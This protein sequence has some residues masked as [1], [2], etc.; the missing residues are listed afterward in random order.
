M[1]FDPVAALQVL[2]R[3]QVRFVLIGR[4]AGRLWGSATMTLE[5]LAAVRDER[6]RPESVD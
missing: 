1:A 2:Q 5:I 3:H 4:V 6:D